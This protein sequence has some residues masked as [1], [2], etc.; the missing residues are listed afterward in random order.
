M[1]KWIKLYT[2]IAD[3]VEKVQKLVILRISVV[4]KKTCKK[5]N[6]IIYYCFFVFILVIYG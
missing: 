6:K 1:S 4:L 3:Y 2:I 5:T